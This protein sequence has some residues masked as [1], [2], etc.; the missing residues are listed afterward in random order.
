MFRTKPSQESLLSSV[1]SE[2]AE[3]VG[4]LEGRHREYR[5]RLESKQQARAALENAEAETKRLHS[6]GVALQRG[7]WEAYYGKGLDTQTEIGPELRSLKRAIEEAEKTLKKARAK[8]EEADFDEVAEWSALIAETNASEE[9]IDRQVDALEETLEDLTAE[10]RH[11]LKD[12]IRSLHDEGQDTQEGVVAPKP[13]GEPK[14]FPRRRGG[15]RLPSLRHLFRRK[16]ETRHLPVATFSLLGGLSCVW[17]GLFEI[18]GEVLVA[19]SLVGIGFINVATV[20]LH[21]LPT[22]WRRNL[23]R[24]RSGAFR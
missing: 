14:R 23:P 17:V 1:R 3:N 9:E 18:K 5:R 10:L 16:P 8:F 20:A 21:T 2:L 15:H 7:F 13:G 22:R 6:E 4:E 24:Q 11:Q 12:A 19:L